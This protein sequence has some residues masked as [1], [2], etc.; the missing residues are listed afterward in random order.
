MVIVKDGERI[1]ALSSDSHKLCG[2][3]LI[4]HCIIE[5]LIYEVFTFLSN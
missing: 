1:N 2:Y 4:G 3:H 5:M